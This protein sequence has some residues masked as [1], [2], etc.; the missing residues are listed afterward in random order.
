MKPKGFV[1]APSMISQ[2]SSSSFSHIR[3][4]SF[5]SA[6]FTARNVFSSSLTISA[7]CVL[8]TGCT[9]SIAWRYSASVTAVQ[10]NWQAMA[11]WA[12]AYKPDAMI[13]LMSPSSEPLDAAMAV[14]L[15]AGKSP[16]L[17]TLLPHHH[18]VTPPPGALSVAEMRK[19]LDQMGVTIPITQLA[20]KQ[21][22]EL[23]K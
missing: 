4:I 19:A 15:V 5:T 11:L 22:I 12:E 9:D 10:A 2:T 23:S 8:E 14:K 21:S 16:N 6:M 3:A 20:P 7:A 1:A 13:F 18:R 17:K